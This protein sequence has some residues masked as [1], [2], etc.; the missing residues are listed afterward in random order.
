MQE[1]LVYVIPKWTE[2]CVSDFK[3]KS[4]RLSEVIE[5]GDRKIYNFET[6]VSE[7]YHRL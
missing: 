2:L 4:P 7:T 3:E 5:E 1:S 6:F